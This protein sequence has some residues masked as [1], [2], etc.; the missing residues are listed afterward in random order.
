MD[1]NFGKV[2]TKLD[3]DADFKVLKKYFSPAVSAFVQLYF[4][5]LG[6]SSRLMLMVRPYYQMNLF[7]RN[8][9]V[10][11]DEIPNTSADTKLRSTCSNLGVESKICVRL[12]Y[13]DK[14][15]KKIK[16][17][18]EKVTVDYTRKK[19]ILDQPSE[20]ITVSGKILEKDTNLPIDAEVS[21]KDVATGVVL[22][23]TKTNA[24]G[25]Y[26]LTIQ[27][28]S[29][30]SITAQSRGYITLHEEAELMA[31]QNQ[32]TKDIFLSKIEVGQSVKL[33]SV[34]FE[35]GTAELIPASFPELD[36]LIDFLHENPTLV[37]ELGGHTSNEGNQDLNLK[38]SEDRVKSVKSYLVSK[39]M[40]ANRIE[41]KAYGS[42]KPLVKNDTEENRKLNRRVE[43]TILK[44]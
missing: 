4:Y 42:T 12:G 33:N 9:K 6:R 37:I 10:V 2:K 5:P 38:L 13:V 1:L 24:N 29:K 30:W 11:N 43:F 35:K 21:I 8:F 39:G 44:Q 17:V 27:E 18:E 40:T 3:T 14:K 15:P 41:I 31:E 20:G 23:K 25:E 16:V 19:E 26:K 36:R 32:L 34:L 22:A 7:S 28:G